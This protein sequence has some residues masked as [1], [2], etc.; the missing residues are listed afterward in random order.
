MESRERVRRSNTNSNQQDPRR[1]VS[2]SPHREELYEKENPLGISWH[3]SRLILIIE[4]V[5]FIYQ[6]FAILQKNKD[7]RDGDK[8]AEAA[9]LVALGLVAGV[10]LT[11]IWSRKHVSPTAMLVFMLGNAFAFLCRQD[12]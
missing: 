9:G 5:L 2:S 7:Y 10:Y 12:R 4:V 3:L 6:T 8:R 1:Q 11:K